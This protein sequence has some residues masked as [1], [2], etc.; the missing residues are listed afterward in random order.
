M[1]ESKTIQ[2]NLVSFDP[3]IALQRVG[4]DMDLLGMAIELGMN[5]LPK[6][7]SRVR[8]AKSGGDAKALRDAAH[9]L[10]GMVGNF[11]ATR[12]HGLAAEIEM[13]A[14]RGDLDQ[15]ADLIVRLESEVQLFG[16]ELAQFAGAADLSGNVVLSS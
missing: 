9:T 13:I 10:K 3:E 8:D 1:S 2:L 16:S 5:N 12:V 11:E 7:M 14:G 6:L 4:G 15:T